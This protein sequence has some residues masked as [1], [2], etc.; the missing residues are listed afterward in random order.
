MRT[1]ETKP[2]QLG[3]G[4]KIIGKKEI[5]KGIIKK[6]EF[7]VVPSGRGYCN[8]RLSQREAEVERIRD[9][10]VLGLSGW[11]TNAIIHVEKNIRGKWKRW[12]IPESSVIGITSKNVKKRKKEVEI[13]IRK[14]SAVL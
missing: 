11:K 9:C 14:D 4:E 5:V 2:V 13:I 8:V 10:K 1:I 6:N 7:I 12:P 3:F